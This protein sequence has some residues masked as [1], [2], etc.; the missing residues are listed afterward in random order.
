MK[1]F[2]Y[3]LLTSLLTILV[4]QSCSEVPQKHDAPRQLIT[5]K[6]AKELN[7][8]YNNTRHR[9]ISSSIQ[10]E[11]ANAIWYSLEE[12][13][14]Y[15]YYIKTEGKNKGYNVDGIRFYLGAYSNNP[16]KYNDKANMTTIFLT[17]TGKKVEVQ[18]GSLL[19]L[20][21][22]IQ[23]QELNPDIEEIEPMNY[24]NMGP[25]PRMEYPSASN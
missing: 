5:N 12:L 14:N 10:K 9:L 17:P 3:L 23:T 11:D 15:I 24:G 19:N 13:E 21:S 2:N 6:E 16:E 25:P 7:D 8:N 22:M 4:F 20:P 18:K 1:K